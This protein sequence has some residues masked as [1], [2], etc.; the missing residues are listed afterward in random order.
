MKKQRRLDGRQDGRRRFLSLL[1]G[2]GTLG[3]VLP[4]LVRR[5]RPEELS[6]READFYRDH[7]LAG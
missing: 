7:D 4:L 3:L 5:E 6:L 2:L 1:G